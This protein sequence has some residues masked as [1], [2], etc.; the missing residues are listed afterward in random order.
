M[1]DMFEKWYLSLN[2]KDCRGSCS[3]SPSDCLDL[4]LGN[5]VF[6][7]YE[8]SVSG[9]MLWGSNPGGKAPTWKNGPLSRGIQTF[10]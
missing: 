5:E 6:R 8:W 9:H 4:P 2:I 3:T 1:Y 10:L 7:R